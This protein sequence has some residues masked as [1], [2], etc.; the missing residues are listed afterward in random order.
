VVGFYQLKRILLDAATLAGTNCFVIGSTEE[1]I[2]IDAGDDCPINKY[3][4]AC[5]AKLMEA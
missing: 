2:M 1:R 5:L 3:F 4:L